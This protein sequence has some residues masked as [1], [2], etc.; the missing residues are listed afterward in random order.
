MFCAFITA[1]LCLK[2]FDILF[3]QECCVTANSKCMAGYKRKDVT[4]LDC[5]TSQKIIMYMY[6]IQIQTTCTFLQTVDLPLYSQSFVI[7][8]LPLSGYLP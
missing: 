1:V 6:Y 7:R 2:S 5:Y 4:S 8:D 3:E